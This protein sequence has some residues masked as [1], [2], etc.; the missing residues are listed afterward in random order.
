MLPR[1]RILSEVLAETAAAYPDHDAFID[2][3][4]RET[5]R[6]LSV[7]VD[8]TA[9]AL[10]Q[11]G[12]RKGDHVAVMLGNSVQ[13]LQTFFACARI[14]AVT[15][16]INTRFKQEELAFCLKQADV[17]TIVLT[18]TF[19]G[20]DFAALLAAVEPALATGLPGEALPTLTQALMFDTSAV[21]PGA[22]NFDQLIASVNDDDIEACQTQSGTVSPDDILL[23]QYTSGTT[24]FPKGVMLSH[25]NML[26]DAYAVSLRMGIKPEDRYFSIRP[27]FH[28][29]GST[30]SILVSLSTGC[31][32][33]TLPKFDVSLA[34]AMLQREK[35]TLTSGNDTIFLM[36]MGH[37]EF[38]AST[39]HLR[40]GWAAAGPEVMQKI[41]DQMNVPHLC[42][43]YGLSEA[44]PNV[45]MS[46]WDDPL[47]LRT[48]GW[49]LPHTGVRVRIIDANTSEILPPGE[50]GEI[51]VKGWSVMHGYYNMP[52]VTARTFTEDGWLKTG[53][54]GKMDRAGRLKMVGRLKDIFRVGGENVAPTEVEGFIL[55]HEA[56]ALAQVVG[57][58]DE[59]LG[60]VPAAFVVL[61]QGYSCTPDELIAWC[62]PRIANFKVPRYVRVVDSFEDIGMTGSSKV[63][64]NKLRAHAISLLGLAESAK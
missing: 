11:R 55:L 40:G 26:S 2:N 50:A 47:P 52:D 18:E 35:C 58:P 54:L 53:D 42:N 33:L 8:R 37:P 41:H 12:V 23:I 56:I 51:Q 24:S 31:C 62:K 10:W 29:A 25:D 13:W 20:I 3:D 45:V 59:R 27:F 43:A 38:D 63:Q 14:G 30:L 21:P 7:R 61:K 6:S 22:I 17:K 4:S 28:V 36:L 32:L 57:V 48:E 46:G 44:S 39:L 34:L 15:V 19:L 5:W 9:A 64:K 60:E 1:G 49:A 16:P